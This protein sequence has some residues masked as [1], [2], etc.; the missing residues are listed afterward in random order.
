MATIVFEIPD[1]ADLEF[2]YFRHY[3]NQRDWYIGL[4]IPYSITN[5][6][7]QSIGGG[8]FH[9]CH[10]DK[11]EA[12]RLAVGRLRD[13]VAIERPKTTPKYQTMGPGLE[14]SK[15]RR[16][17]VDDKEVDELFNQLMKSL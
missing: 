4:R 14:T 6:G 16:S 3:S 15:R 13:W 5:A 7:G 9:G 10:A 8:I 17:A 2:A 12:I 1:D 11:E